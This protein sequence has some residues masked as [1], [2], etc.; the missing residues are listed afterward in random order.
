MKAKKI[1]LHIVLPI[2]VGTAIYICWRTKSLQVFS[3][4]RFFGMDSFVVLCRMKSAFFREYLPDFVV[5]SLPNGLWVYSLT[6]FMC[7]LWKG[8]QASLARAF[9][10]SLGFGLGVGLEIGQLLGV[11]PGTFDFA[12]LSISL[13]AALAATAFAPKRQLDRNILSSQENV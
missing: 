9:W 12:D 2:I 10:L 3:W 13:V 7:L 11:V 5:F 8:E 1:L 4:L 6:S